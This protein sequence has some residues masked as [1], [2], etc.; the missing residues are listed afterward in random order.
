[1]NSHNRQNNQSEN[2]VF[3]FLYHDARRIASFLA[4][5]EAYGTPSGVRASQSATETS[6]DGSGS[7]ISGS[8]AGA[9]TGRKNTNT[10]VA[11]VVADGLERTYDPLWRN[12]ILLLDYL[13]D[14][15]LIRPDIAKAQFGQFVRAD[16]ELTFG[17]LTFLQKAWNDE[18]LSD[19]LRGAEDE[20]SE[21]NR[22]ERRRSSRS[23]K[24]SKG[25]DPMLEKMLAYLRIIPHGMQASFATKEGI[26]V[27][28]TLEEQ[29]LVPSGSDIILKHGL[30]VPGQWTVIG[31]LDAK[32]SANIFNDTDEELKIEPGQ[33]KYGAV[34]GLAGM[35]LRPMSNTART[36]LGRPPEAF[37]LTPLMI[38]RQVSGG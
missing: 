29:S 4:Q 35:A 12:A 18:I 31:I 5:F 16:G 14:R 8:L 30:S 13:T 9:I 20:E 27:W 33:I 25:S 15:Q 37:G 32:P 2:S 34:G 7:Q 22:A 36:L 11:S 6:Q 26:S 28:C 24:P 19:I 38:L 21:S 3:D 1:M 17:D 23:K 10:S